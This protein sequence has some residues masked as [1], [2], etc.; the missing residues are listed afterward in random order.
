MFFF[1]ILYHLVSNEKIPICIEKNPQQSSGEIKPW[2]PWES[3]KSVKKIL[4]SFF[5]NWL[6]QVILCIT[7]HAL[8]QM[9]AEK[10][11]AQRRHE[12]AEEVYMVHKMLARLQASLE[13]SHEASAQAV[14]Q[15]RQAQDQLDGVKNQYQDI[16]S[17]AKKQRMQ[18]EKVDKPVLF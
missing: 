7:T 17:Q 15:R 11:E 3:K 4:G 8:L 6:I 13:A 12:L 1:N 9:V 16:A 18:G 5:N 10:A 14:A 2:A